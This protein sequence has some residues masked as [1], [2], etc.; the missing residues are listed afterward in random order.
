MLR[1]P[2]GALQLYPSQTKNLEGLTKDEI[3]IS[4]EALFKGAS[5]V[6]NKKKMA[7]FRTHYLT[8]KSACV[9]TQSSGQ[10]N[11]F[12]LTHFSVDWKVA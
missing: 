7:Q 11:T 2:V 9:S 8:K 10:L 12:L 1:C 5:H 3:R 4:K 6:A